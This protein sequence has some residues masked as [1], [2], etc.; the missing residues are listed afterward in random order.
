MKKLTLVLIFIIF[1]LLLLAS[2]LIYGWTRDI[3]KDAMENA[4]FSATM[5]DAGG[6][7]CNSAF[8][9]SFDEAISSAA[10]NKALTVSP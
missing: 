2:W 5:E 4:F 3:S 7:D 8:K 9:L 6:V 10:V 1:A